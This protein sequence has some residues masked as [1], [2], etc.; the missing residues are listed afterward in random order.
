MRAMR[1][2]AIFRLARRWPYCLQQIGALFL[3]TLRCVHAWTSV[4]LVPPT[5]R[6]RSRISAVL[7]GWQLRDAT[8]M[9]RTSPSECQARRVRLPDSIESIGTTTSSFTPPWITKPR[10]NTRKPTMLDKSASYPTMPPTKRRHSSRT[11]SALGDQGRVAAP[12]EPRFTSVAV[13][14]GDS[15]AAVGCCMRR[16]TRLAAA[17][18]MS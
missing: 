2:L 16:M 4:M 8:G 3:H 7:N 11:S 10:R 1:G 14:V 5:L 18:P 6:G 12:T 17:A 9:V 15:T 13:K